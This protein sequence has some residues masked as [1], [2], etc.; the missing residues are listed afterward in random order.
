MG[1]DIIYLKKHLNNFFKVAGVPKQHSV[2]IEVG[3]NIFFG[4]RQQNQ[5]TRRIALKIGY[6]PTNFKET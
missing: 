4:Q 2:P 5:I 3:E 6:D 1:D